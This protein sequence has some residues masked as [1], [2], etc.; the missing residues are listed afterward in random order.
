VCVA[1]LLPPPSPDNSTRAALGRYIQEVSK[2]SE[3]WVQPHEVEA[4][5]VHALDNP[6]NLEDV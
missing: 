2:M 3:S 6:I 1:C 5:I 4:R